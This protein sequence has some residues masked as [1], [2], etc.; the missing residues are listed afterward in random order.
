MYLLSINVRIIF[1]YSISLDQKH[2]TAY[3]TFS[4]GNKLIKH[5][6]KHLYVLFRNLSHFGLKLAKLKIS[7]F[8]INIG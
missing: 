7:I 6:I 3:F 2:L 4:P 1:S 8:N 5:I